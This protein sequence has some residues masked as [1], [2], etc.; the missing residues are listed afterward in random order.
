VTE[1][2]ESE[3]SGYRWGERA[4]VEYLRQ[5]LKLAP[6]PSRVKLPLAPYIDRAPHTLCPFRMRGQRADAAQRELGV[7]MRHGMTLTE[8]RKRG[9]VTS[10]TR[11][12]DRA[13]SDV[14]YAG[15]RM[16]RQ[17]G[18]RQIMRTFCMGWVNSPGWSCSPSAERA[19]SAPARRDAGGAKCERP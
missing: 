1:N 14:V 17:P 15:F 18:G 9:E 3:P 4:E 8:V 2:G 13:R 19:T 6:R 5:S 10:P 7:A 16:S 12:L 11:L